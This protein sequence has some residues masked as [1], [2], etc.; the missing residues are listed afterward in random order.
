MWVKEGQGLEKRWALEKKNGDI[1]WFKRGGTGCKTRDVRVCEL[2]TNTDTKRE[3][4]GPR[5]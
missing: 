1:I 3:G 2:C 4:G 5:S